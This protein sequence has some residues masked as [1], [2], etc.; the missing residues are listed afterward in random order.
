M[1]RIPSR[2]EP[3]HSVAKCNRHWKTKREFVTKAANKASHV[4]GS[5]YLLICVAPKGN[6]EVHASEYFYDDANQHK[7]DGIIN[8]EVLRG[9]AEFIQTRNESRW[10]EVERQEKR[11]G[12]EDDA[13]DEDNEDG[14]DVDSNDLSLGDLNLPDTPTGGQTQLMSTFSA[15]NPS[16][17]TIGPVSSITVT[18]ATIDREYHA[19]FEHLGQNVCANVLKAWIK[20]VEPKKQTK[21][22]YKDKKGNEGRP[23]PWWPTGLRH[24]E[25]DHLHKDERPRLL[26][27]ILQ[28]ASKPRSESARQAAALANVAGANAR[29][30]LDQR[31]E[32]T[33]SRLHFATAEI[34]SSIP[35]RQHFELRQIYLIAKEV[36]KANEDSAKERRNAASREG[37]VFIEDDTFVPTWVELT[38][39]FFERHPSASH[40]QKRMS[41]DLMMGMGKENVDFDSRILKRGKRELTMAPLTTDIHHPALTP[42]G[43]HTNVYSTVPYG[44]DAGTPHT[45]HT[46]HTPAHGYQSWQPITVP[47]SATTPQLTQAQQQQQH[48]AQYYPRSAPP[49]FALDVNYQAS[50]SY[51]NNGT[52][53]PTTATQPTYS[54]SSQGSIGGSASAPGTT[55]PAYQP[56]VPQGLSYHSPYSS[57]GS[58]TAAAAYTTPQYTHSGYPAATSYDTGQAFVSDLA[59]LSA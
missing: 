58:A 28:Q 13:D 21:Y 24:I 50:H 41:D 26:T 55:A 37:T 12:L 15:S 49:T 17:M 46:P 18:P 23:P 52:P 3:Y 32:L 47:Q 27:S 8:W 5:H 10:Q 54:H 14:E 48:A 16:K 35:P 7:A 39:D 20:V 40:S 29:P 43:S 34:A 57:T 45:P 38:V 1:P 53:T 56:Y 25:P 4:D 6:I 22:P 11:F 36:R 2:E 31:S 59:G 30:T 19:R 33:I 44:M 9:R 42:L 51:T